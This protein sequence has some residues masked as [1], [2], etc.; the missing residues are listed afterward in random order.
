ML[1]WWCRSPIY[2]LANTWAFKTQLTSGSSKQDNPPKW[3][4]KR[5]LLINHSRNKTK[6]TLSM[7]LDLAVSLKNHMLR[8]KTKI[9]A[10]LVI[11]DRVPG[12]RLA[13]AWTL[14][15][16]SQWLARV[17][18]LNQMLEIDHHLYSAKSTRLA[19]VNLISDRVFVYGPFLNSTRKLAQTDLAWF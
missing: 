19:K 7:T 18:Y 4:T 14:V 9:R 5:W 13:R 3:T 11:L 2:F 6:C 1:N 12:H 8:W 10:Q 15:Q 16:I 17:F